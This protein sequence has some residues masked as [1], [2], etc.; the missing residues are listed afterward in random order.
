MNEKNYY[1]EIIEEIKK[2][3]ETDLEQAVLLL[4]K[5]LSMPY[6]PSEYNDQMNKL[7]Q[8]Y[9]VKFDDKKITMTRDE[10]LNILNSEN[11]SPGKQSLALTQISQ[12][13]WVGFEDT[14]QNILV[15][16]K[17]ANN[18]K[19]VFLES[20]IAQK[21]D[22]NFKIDQLIMNPSKMKSIFDSEYC[23][24]NI[25]GIESK[26]LK[27]LVVKRIAMESFLIYISTIFPYNIDMKYFDHVEEMILVAH[28]LLGESNSIADNDVAT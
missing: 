8:E 20:L 22:Y 26:D 2:I 9:T 28:A 10:L 27:D 5:E 18:A 15:S 12:F 25:M 3:K 17:I 21:L 23:I 13:N 16:T 7:F 14:I 24:K 19:T 4:K 11:S 1:K 6:I